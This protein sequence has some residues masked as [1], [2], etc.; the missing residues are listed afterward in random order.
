MTSEQEEGDQEG[1]V[2]REEKE[3]HARCSF[4]KNN[5]KCWTKYLRVK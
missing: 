2:K 4:F 3:C 1:R 5:H